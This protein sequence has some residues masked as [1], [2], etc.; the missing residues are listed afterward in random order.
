MR[1]AANLAVDLAD[2]GDDG[3]GLCTAA[4]G[5]E[6]DEAGSAAKAA[7]HVGAE[8]RMVPHAGQDSRMQHLQQEAGDAA[9][10]HGGDIAMDAPGD[11]ARAEE[12]V[13][14]AGDRAFAAGLVVE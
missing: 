1:S 7:V 4:V 11:G 8:I 10:H 5:R 2:A 9:D 14:L 12:P 6:R 3:F 13:H